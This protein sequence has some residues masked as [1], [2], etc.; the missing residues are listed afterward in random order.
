MLAATM[1][2]PWKSRLRLMTLRLSGCP[3]AAWYD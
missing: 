2:L 1:V 3:R